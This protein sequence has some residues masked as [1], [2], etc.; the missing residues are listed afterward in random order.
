MLHDVSPE[1]ALRFK[2]LDLNL[3]PL[4]DT[5]IEQRSTIRAAEHHNLSQ[6]AISAA[7]Q[8]LRV[9]FRNPLL[10]PQGRKMVPTAFAMQLLP[11]LKALLSDAEIIINTSS[12]FDP[13]TSQRTFRISIS[14]YLTIV[15]FGPL[16]Q[17]LATEAPGL[18]YEFLQPAD[19]LAQQIDRGDIDL[20]ISPMEYLIPEHPSQFLCEETYVVAGWSGNTLLDGAMSL[21][22]FCAAEH[23]AVR[24]GRINRSS[25]A[26]SQLRAMGIERKTVIQATTFGLVPE[27]LVGTG[28][29]AIMHR[30]LAKHAAKNLPLRFGPLPFEFPPLVEGIQFHRS[31]I[32]DS[33]LK[34]LVDEIRSECDKLGSGNDAVQTLADAARRGQ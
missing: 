23:V 26:E 25:I 14:D 28:R 24:L 8:R 30:R 16:L 7:L 22:Q 20:V 10:V 13:K 32:N 33:G 12:D 17:R 9:Y 34:W 21:E 6:P 1:V 11:H 27:L 3:V 2:G 31:R 19:E 29:I 4:L 18:S 15:V 5:L